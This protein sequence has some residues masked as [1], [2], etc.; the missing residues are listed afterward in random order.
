LKTESSDK[1]VDVCKI[2][3]CGEYKGELDPYPDFPESSSDE[4]KLKMASELK[5]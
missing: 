4:E 5:K 2:E 1:P 3:E